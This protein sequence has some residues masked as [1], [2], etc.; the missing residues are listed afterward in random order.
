MEINADEIKFLRSMIRK[1]RK[2]KMEN[3]RLE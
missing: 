2:D 1:M 3:E